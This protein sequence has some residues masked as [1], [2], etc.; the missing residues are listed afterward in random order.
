MHKVDGTTWFLVADGGKAVVYESRDFR[1]GWKQVGKW[2]N[3]EGHK[4]DSELSAS[5][6]TRG[7]KTGSGARFSV[8]ESSAHVRSEA[9]FIAERASWLDDCARERRFDNL[10]I[11]IAP[12]ALGEFRRHMSDAVSSRVAASFDK[13]LTRLPEAELLDYFRGHMGRS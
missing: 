4:R 12:H 8:D 3:E 13:D 6:P 7:Y 2:D 10:V 1:D 11:A 5:P 9:D